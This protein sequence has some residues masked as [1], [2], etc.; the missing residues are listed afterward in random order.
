MLELA[1]SVLHIEVVSNSEHEA[2]ILITECRQ[3]K[4]VL[5]NKSSSSVLQLQQRGTLRGYNRRSIN[6]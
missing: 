4:I 2:D 5:L 3:A 6:Q 1:V